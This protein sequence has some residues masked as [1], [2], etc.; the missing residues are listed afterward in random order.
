MQ[1]NRVDN[2][3]NFNGIKLKSITTPLKKIDIY[4]LDCRDNE[5]V[6]RFVSDIKNN[7]VNKRIITIGND[8]PENITLDALKQVSKIEKDSYTPK[9]L[10]SVE[11]DKNVTGIIC[12]EKEGDMKVR[13][14]AVWSKDSNARTSLLHTLLDETEK[15][16]K[17]SLIIPVDKMTRQMQAFCRKLGFIKPKDYPS[18]YVVDLPDMVHVLTNLE[19][20]PDYKVKTYQQNNFTNLENLIDNYV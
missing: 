2:R 9:V 12:A 14:M 7:G 17:F 8:S 6:N 11:D 10:I 19:K 13:G 3:T 4:S 5:F 16:Q 1:I 15:L 20:L 18:G